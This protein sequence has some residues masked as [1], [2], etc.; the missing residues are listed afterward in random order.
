MQSQGLILHR[1]MY[2]TFQSQYRNQI[3]PTCI[4]QPS[5]S[6]SL[7][8]IYD[9]FQASIEAHHKVVPMSLSLIHRLMNESG[10]FPQKQIF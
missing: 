9:H 6:W 8:Y 5:I 7:H 10:I 4:H 1:L 2:S 3:Y